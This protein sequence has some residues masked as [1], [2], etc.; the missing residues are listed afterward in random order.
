[1]AAKELVDQWL[2]LYT[3]KKELEAE[4]K[5]IEQDI[6][7]LE[8]VAISALNNEGTSE[9]RDTNTGRKVY[10]YAETR[11]KVD[12]ENRRALVAALKVNGLENLV[13]EDFNLNSLRSVMLEWIKTAKPLNLE[14]AIPDAFRGLMQISTTVSLRAGKPTDPNNPTKGNEDDDEPF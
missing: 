12:P 2:A 10:L 4:L 3:R 8:R 1:M 5:Q 14:D 13:K 6:K 11:P 7:P 9:L